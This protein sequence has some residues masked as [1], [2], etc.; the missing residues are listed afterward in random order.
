MLKL[1]SA[2]S[3]FFVNN[4]G[5]IELGLVFDDKGSSGA[6][7]SHFT[8]W[9]ISEIPLPAA[10]PMFLLVLGGTALVARRRRGVAGV[11]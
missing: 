7:F 9:G 11:A 6:G 2:G 10:L 1:G 4:A 8:E 5:L 3:F